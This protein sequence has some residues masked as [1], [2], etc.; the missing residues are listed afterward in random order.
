MCVICKGLGYEIAN[1]VPRPWPVPVAAGLFGDPDE[2]EARRCPT[3]RR[4][5]AWSGHGSRH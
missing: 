5:P 4:A 2:V 3:D 1:R